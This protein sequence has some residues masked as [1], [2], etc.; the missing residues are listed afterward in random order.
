MEARRNAFD[1]MPL[2]LNNVSEKLVQGMLSC[3]LE[4]VV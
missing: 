1:A 2:I 4:F 3:M